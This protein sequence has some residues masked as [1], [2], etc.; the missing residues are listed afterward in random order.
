MADKEIWRPIP[1]HK[2]YEASSHGR[3]RSVDRLVTS[4]TPPR[5]LKGK[6]LKQF[7]LWNGY[8]TTHLGKAHANKYVHRLVALAFFGP[9]PQGME[10]CHGDDNKQNPRLD[11]LRYDTRKGNMAD[12]RHAPHPK[13]GRRPAGLD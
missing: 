12:R 11:N 13:Q 5:R 8:K 9:P 4:Y 10:V 1:G 3:I 7:I 6:V 2:G